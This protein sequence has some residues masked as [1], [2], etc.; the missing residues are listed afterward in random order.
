MGWMAIWWLLIPV[1]ITVLVW[2][3]LRSARE[4]SGTPESPEQIVKRR[5]ARGEIDRDTYERLLSDLKRA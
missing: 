5:Y 3:V 1:L 2:G 4:P